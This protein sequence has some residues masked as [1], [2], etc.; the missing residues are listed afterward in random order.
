M[1]GVL[2]RHP[3]EVRFA[4]L[5]LRSLLPGHN[6]L[7]DEL[8]WIT[9]RAIRW[10]RSYLKPHMKVFEYGAGG[11]TLFLA[12]RVR[13]LVS[14]EHDETFYSVISDRLTN[15]GIQN[16]RLV[17]CRPEKRSLQAPPDVAYGTASYTSF[18]QRHGGEWFEKYVKVIDEYPDGYF[19]LVVVD[20]R[21]R[22]SC[23]SRSLSKI[24]P[25]GALLLDNSE[26][27]A[28]AVARRLL[29]GYPCFDMFGIVPWNLV[30]YQTSVW[31]IDSQGNSSDGYGREPG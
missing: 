19:D 15:Q 7:D 3:Q 26:R 27:P 10:L 29:D 18:E 17:L 4:H 22:A 23:V 5:W 30:P 8:P 6:P 11:S 13:E 12:K 31:R 1:A 9:F 21:A 16:C 25:A 2:I 28:Y 20:G 24:R 14:V